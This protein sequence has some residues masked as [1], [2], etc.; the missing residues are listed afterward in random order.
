MSSEIEELLLKVG[1]YISIHDEAT[2]AIRSQDETYLDRHL[3][4]YKQM[5]DCYERISMER[6]GGRDYRQPA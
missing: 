3:E 2:E 5:R 4:A 1:E 6:I